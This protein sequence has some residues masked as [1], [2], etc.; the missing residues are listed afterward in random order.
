VCVSEARL[1]SSKIDVAGS[2]R[3]VT[4]GEQAVSYIVYDEW[5]T[6]WTFEQALTCED[7]L[8]APDAT[9]EELCLGFPP[10]PESFQPAYL[11]GKAMT[12]SQK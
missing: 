8:A 7:L 11:T 2:E 4:G 5:V 3:R 1:T 9:M 12:Y 10:P 6:V